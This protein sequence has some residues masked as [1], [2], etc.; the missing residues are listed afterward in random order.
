MSEKMIDQKP[1]IALANDL[2]I[3]FEYLDRIPQE[4][5]DKL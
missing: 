1:R 2:K 5:S 3:P 4:V